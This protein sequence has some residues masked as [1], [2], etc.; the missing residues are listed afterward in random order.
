MSLSELSVLSAD[1]A[2]SIHEED[3]E[4]IKEDQ[5]IETNEVRMATGKE[6][7]P[8]NTIST[9]IFVA[10]DD[11]NL[12]NGPEENTFIYEKLVF[13]VK[14]IIENGVRRVF[15]TVQSSSPSEWQLLVQLRIKTGCQWNILNVVDKDVFKFDSFS[16]PLDVQIENDDVKCLKFEMRVLNFMTFIERFQAA[17]Q[18][19]LE[20]AIR[21]LAFRAAIDGT[22][23][24][25][26]QGGFEP[27]NFC[28]RQE[29]DTTKSTI[30]FRGTKF[31]INSG[32]LAAHGKEMLCIGQNE[33]FI[34]R[35][36][37]DFHRECARGDLIPGEVLIQLLTYMHPMGSVPHPDMIRACIVFA[38]DHG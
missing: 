4:R 35:Y 36:T 20:P 13:R 14:Q 30:L 5:K 25:M 11:Q 7:R 24:H 18:N 22:W 16:Y 38:Y 17:I 12:R 19:R 3:L 28:G 21:E 1:T 33:E 23:N 2:I 32:L 10:V 37:P 26:I 29:G 9:V 6:M 8:E 31:Y 27:E 15:L 34:A